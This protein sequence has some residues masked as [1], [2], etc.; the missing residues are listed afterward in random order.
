MLPDICHQAMTTDDAFTVNTFSTIHH[1]LKRFSV[2]YVET[3]LY[4]PTHL[5]PLPWFAGNALKIKR[6]ERE[7]RRSRKQSRR[8]KGKESRKT[9]KQRRRKMDIT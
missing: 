7:Q 8:R 2:K 9:E 6:G 1:T 4:R 5:A 3:K